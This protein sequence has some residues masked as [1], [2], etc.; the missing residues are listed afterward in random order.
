MKADLQHFRAQ[1][2]DNCHRVA[3]RMS[4]KAR[5]LFESKLP[6]L[7]V[8]VTAI[9]CSGVPSSAIKYH[10]SLVVNAGR[11]VTE[12]MSECPKC[13]GDQMYGTVTPPRRTHPHSICEDLA[14]ALAKDGTPR[15]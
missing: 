3:L 10:L 1:A 14:D 6:P 2:G 8:Q 11:G 13:G 4:A 5:R 9:D 15:A 7:S 12:L